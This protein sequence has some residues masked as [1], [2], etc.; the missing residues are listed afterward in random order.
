MGFVIRAALVV[1]IVYALSPMRDAR[2]PLGREA[3]SALEGLPSRAA[4]AALALCGEQV[5]CLAR[6][7]GLAAQVATPA[8]TGTARPDAR[9]EVRARGGTTLQRP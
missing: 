4:D 7:A 2:E 3:A 8:M 1:G 5:A 9:P 6:A